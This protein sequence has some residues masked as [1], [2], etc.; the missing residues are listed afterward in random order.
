M[1]WRRVAWPS[2]STI[3][4]ILTLDNL[5]RSPFKWV[6]LVP[7]EW[8]A[9][10]AIYNM[11][12]LFIKDLLGAMCPIDKFEHYFITNG[13]IIWEFLHSIKVLDPLPLPFSSSRLSLRL[14][15]GHLIS[16][17]ALHLSYPKLQLAFNLINE[18]WTQEALL[19]PWLLGVIYAAQLRRRLLLPRSC[20]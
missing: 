1:N 15:H 5:A 9:I 18:I 20:F 14:S 7:I 19:L 17:I 4:R 10:I 8:E 16:L 2:A 6:V 13:F 12:W 3:L 11:L